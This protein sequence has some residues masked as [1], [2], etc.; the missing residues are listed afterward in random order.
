M[1]ASEFID[2]T[3]VHLGGMTE[4]EQPNVRIT[5][6]PK[7]TG[8]VE[9]KASIDGKEVGFVVFRKLKDGKSK[10]TFV[11]VSEPLRR[12]GIGSAMY[13]YARDKLGLDLVPSDSQTELG[14]IFWNKVHENES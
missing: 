14:K 12:K 10:A 5:H 9:I 8:G 11:Y 7:E 3:S 4:D 6:E 13:K 1:R 2:A